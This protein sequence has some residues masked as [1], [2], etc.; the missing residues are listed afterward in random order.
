MTP[1]IHEGT[2]KSTGGAQRNHNSFP[3]GNFADYILCT[4]I[5]MS[6]EIE[7][8][9]KT[10]TLIATSFKITMINPLNLYI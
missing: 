4:S 3:K 7:F 8:V 1:N 6:R 10:K 2:C 9:D 5:N